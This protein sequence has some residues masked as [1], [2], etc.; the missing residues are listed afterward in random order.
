MLVGLPGDELSQLRKDSQPSL[1]KNGSVLFEREKFHCSFWSL[2]YNWRQDT[3]RVWSAR[4]LCTWKRV[5]TKSSGCI[6]HTSKKPALPP[7]AI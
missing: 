5:F 7:A 4:L 3:F 6:K 1:R 2:G